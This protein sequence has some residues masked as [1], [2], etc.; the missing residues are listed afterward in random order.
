MRGVNIGVVTALPREAG[1]LGVG[2]ICVGRVVG[3]GRLRVVASGMG[4]D[5]AAR[6]ART[7]CAGGID[8]LVSWG[9]AGALSDSLERGNLI[10]VDA[11]QERGETMP[12]DFAWR[13]RLAVALDDKRVRFRSGCVCCCDHAVG[14]VAEKRRLAARG[15]SIVDMESAGVAQVA[16]QAQVPFVAVK[17][18]C[19]PLQRELPPVIAQLLSPDGRVRWRVL[20]AVLARGP[21]AWRSLF[22]LRAD[23]AAACATLETAAAAVFSS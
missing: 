9:V 10:L 12:V 14:S 18:V 2:R 20:A 22:L 4:R 16:R 15:C 3:A 7:L 11:I 13:K 8:V 1:T 19:D 6:A 23:F 17:T 21:A 5:N